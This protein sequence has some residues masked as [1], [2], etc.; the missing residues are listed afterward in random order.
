MVNPTRLPRRTGISIND[1]VSLAPENSQY[2][3]LF[4]LYVTHWW[5]SLVNYVPGLRV[6]GDEWHIGYDIPSDA[7]NRV[8]S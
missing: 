1:F 2:L 3:A 5:G 7:I 8:R 6:D 4:K